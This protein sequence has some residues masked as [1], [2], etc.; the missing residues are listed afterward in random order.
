MPVAIV[1]GSDSG[2]GRATAFQ[3]ARDGFD[4]GVTWQTDEDAL[5]GVSTTTGGTR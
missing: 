3:L 1:T 5:G 2:I 4:V